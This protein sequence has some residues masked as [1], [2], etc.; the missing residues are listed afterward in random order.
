MNEFTSE[1]IAKVRLSSHLIEPPAAEVIG[2]LL[3]E[4]TRLQSRVQELESEQR[5]MIHKD[6]K[7]MLAVK[8][9]DRW[10][11]VLPNFINLQVSESYWVTDNL[12]TLQVNDFI[13]DVYQ[14]LLPNHQRTVNDGIY[15]LD[16]PFFEVSL[17][18]SR[19]C[20]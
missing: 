17:W 20:E 7:K 5:W 15:N 13:E 1:W 9:G 10:C 19:I 16:Y 2:E 3:D 8:D 12:V 18:V 4:I 6:A 14:T 11:F